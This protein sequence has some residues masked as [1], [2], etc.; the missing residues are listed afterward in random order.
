M[1]V[2][3]HTFIVL[4][5]GANYYNFSGR[6]R[7]SHG[8]CRAIR[9]LPTSD[10]GAFRQK[11]VQNGKNWILLGGGVPPAPP[12]SANEF[13]FKNVMVPTTTYIK[14]PKYQIVYISKLLNCVDIYYF[15]LYSM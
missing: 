5:N 14:L 9:G 10:T 11:C 1:T 7:I 2:Y 13:S 3:F 12:E 15:I 4:F 6:S 8:G